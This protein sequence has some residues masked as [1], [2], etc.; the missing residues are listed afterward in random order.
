MAAKRSIV[1]LCMPYAF[2]N[3]LILSLCLWVNSW[4]SLQAVF[5]TQQ[6][7]KGMP[8]LPMACFKDTC[9]ESLV[10]NS[11]LTE[12]P[13]TESQGRFKNYSIPTKNSVQSPLK[14]P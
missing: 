9:T 8:L 10:A 1:Q 5:Q 7:I 13:D 11:L 6:K 12:I 2:H 3:Y 14:A 4:K